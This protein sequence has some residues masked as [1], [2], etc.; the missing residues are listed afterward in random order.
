MNRSSDWN[1]F[2]TND[3]DWTTSSRL[4]PLAELER[5]Q[6]PF[7]GP[8]RFA[9]IRPDEDWD[10]D[11]TVTERFPSAK[12]S[13]TCHAAWII[14]RLPATKRKRHDPINGNFRECKLQL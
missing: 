2:Q 4:S 7:A 5:T 1:P 11:I 3:F 13:K 12:L 6:W 10:D 9:E 8:S 14:A